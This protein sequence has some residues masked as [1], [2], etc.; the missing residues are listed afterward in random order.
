MKVIGIVGG[1]ASGKSLVAEQL[2]RLGA[3]ILE[4]D[5]VGHAV[6]REPEIIRALRERWGDSVVDQD[7]QINRAAV[8]QIV[9]APP[10]RGIEQLAFLE[11]LTHPRIGTRLQARL[12]ELAQ[13]RETCVVVLD[14][15]VLL[16]A[17][18]DRFCDKILFVEASRAQRVE[19]ARQRGWSEAEF[20]AREAAQEAL[21]EKRNRAD[22]VIDN[23][24]S[25]TETWRQVEA[26]WR[27]LA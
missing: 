5:R 25:P 3:V 15:A 4:A 13:D 18:W 23:S 17:G 8:A 22:V 14:A 6:L 16:K 2:Q 20:A 19:R 12:Q 26:L 7:G 11:Q 1:V 24:G 21:E 9:F 27:S 10:P